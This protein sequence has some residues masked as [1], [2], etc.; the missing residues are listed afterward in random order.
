MVKVATEAAPEAASEV[1]EDAERQADAML[2]RVATLPE[3]SMRTARVGQILMSNSPQQNVAVLDT[4]ICK[5]MAR[6]QEAERALLSVSMWLI[7]LHARNDP[8]DAP[9]AYEMTRALYEA[10]A[11]AELP[12]VTYLLLELPPHRRLANRRALE[13]HQRFDR[14]V[15]LGERKQLAA[16]NDRLM[17]ERL[18]LDADP[19]VIRRVCANPR[20][21]Q[22]DILRICTRRPNTPEALTE[23]ALNRRWIVRYEVRRAILLNP[24]A[25]TGLGLKFLP[26][27]RRPDLQ[28]VAQAGDLHPALCQTA[29]RLLQI[30][31][32]LQGLR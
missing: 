28:D 21:S 27:L 14:E 8:K 6:Q 3:W 29:R 16:G 31:E 15:T 26:L 9:V 17:I 13:K 19:S 10:A 11:E 25:P 23:V 4:L 24:F 5:T 7:A 20:V 32:N 30:R 1:F 18:I 2:T 22:T 12:H